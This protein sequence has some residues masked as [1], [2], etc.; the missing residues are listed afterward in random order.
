MAAAKSLEAWLETPMLKAHNVQIIDHRQIA[1]LATR[2]RAV[3]RKRTHLQCTKARS[4]PS[5]GLLSC[6]NRIPTCGRITI[7]D[8]GRCWSYS[9][10]EAIC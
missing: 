3:P 10:A 8:S 7:R 1:E 2:A 6:S 4:V 5:S 9:K